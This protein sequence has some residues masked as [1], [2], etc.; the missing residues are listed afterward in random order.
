MRILLLD[1]YDSFVYNLKQYMGELGADV[2]VL[3][4][5]AID[6]EGV[7]RFDPDAI[8]IS[9]GPGHP[10][11]K[12]D[13]GVCAEVL[14]GISHTVPTLGVC[15]G[16]QGIAHCYGGNV[17]KA[18]HLMHG[19]TSVIGHDGEG[20][21][22]GLE[23]PLVVGRYHS[24]VVGHDLPQCLKVSAVASDGTIMGIRHLQFPIEGVQFHP[25]S[26][27]TPNGKSMMANF[28]AGARC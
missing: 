23:D 28:I 19:K 11:V 3:R 1:N 14:T 21:F 6:A 10:A 26:I 25:E 8:V 12:R 13:F 2:T 22:A 27:L 18:E 20:V 9:P 17:V 7:R 16:H 24:L 5:D 4:N 15:L